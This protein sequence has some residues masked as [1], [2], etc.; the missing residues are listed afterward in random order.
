MRDVRHSTAAALAV[1]LLVE[2]LGVTKLRGTRHFITSGCETF[3]AGMPGTSLHDKE[4]K[5]AAVVARVSQALQRR[6][7]SSEGRE[8]A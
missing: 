7:F 1:E 4:M 6:Y 3:A 2:A 8:K 5:P